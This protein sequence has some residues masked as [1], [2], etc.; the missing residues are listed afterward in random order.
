M[1]RGRAVHTID[2]KGR[3]SIPAGYRVE[4]ERRSDRP[5][6][7]TNM[8]DCLALY[9]YED[10]ENIERQLAAASPMQ[11]E[12]QALQRFLISGAVEGQIDKQGRILI[13]AYLRDHAG[14]ERD[15]TVAGVGPRIELWDKRRFD[16]NLART[17]E[18]YKEISAVVAASPP[19]GGFQGGSGGGGSFA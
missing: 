4:L 13:P 12:V 17:Q 2:P 8:L 18:E 14:L 15:V 7:L 6:I 19:R 1:F 5:P 10:W 9:P 3:L 16:E 11:L